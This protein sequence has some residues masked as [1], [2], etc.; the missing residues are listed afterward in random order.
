MTNSK[1]TSRGVRYDVAMPASPRQHEPDMPADAAT[2]DG[3]DI[4][5][6]RWMLSPTPMQRL[7]V[8]QQQVDA[9]AKLRDAR[10]TPR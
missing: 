3:V 1:T 9:I 4:T 2:D 10:E 7:S 5:L 8:L 6:I